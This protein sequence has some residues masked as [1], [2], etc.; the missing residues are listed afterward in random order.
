MVNQRISITD[1]EIDNFLNSE[2]GRTVMAADY[3]VDHLLIPVGEGDANTV[4]EAKLQFASELVAAIEET[5]NLAQ[6]RD[7][8]LAQGRFPVTGTNFGYRQLAQIPS[9]FAD[10]V[11]EMAIGSVA[12]PIRAGNG[13]HVILLSDIQGGTDQ[14]VK[15]THFRHIM[16]MP[17][18]IRT[19]DQALALL[20][21]LRERVIAG[22]SF[23]SMARQNSDDPSSVVAGGDLDWVREGGMPESMEAVVNA[24]EIGDISEPFRTG[25]GWHIV[26]VLGRRDEDLSAEFGKVQAENA[27]RTRK[28]DLELQNWLSEL[29]E[30]AFVEFKE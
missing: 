11:P 24:A 10:V 30:S 28:F 6:I 25:D 22:E 1:Q 15:Q 7:S 17:N 27:L 19:D 29:R 3:L 5:G 23:A 13:F 8:A 21:N 4:I 18:E 9:L 2:M 26:E 20:T 16:I 14:I 12:G